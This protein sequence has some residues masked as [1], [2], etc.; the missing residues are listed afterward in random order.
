MGLVGLS[1][2]GCGGC[3]GGCG[4]LLD[5][6]RI[7]NLSVLLMIVSFINIIIINF[8]NIDIKWLSPCLLPFNQ[9]LFFVFSIIINISITIIII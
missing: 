3:S 8:N 6:L 9:L 2:G 7:F 4:D 5:G 1:E